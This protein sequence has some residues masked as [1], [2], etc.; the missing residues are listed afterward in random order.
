MLKDKDKF[1]CWAS[2][3]VQVSYWCQAETVVHGSYILGLN[4]VSSAASSKEKE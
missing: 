4:S 1:L 2:L 3:Q